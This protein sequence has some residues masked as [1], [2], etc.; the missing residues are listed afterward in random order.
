MLLGVFCAKGLAPL[1]CMAACALVDLL[2]QHLK[3]IEPEAGRKGGNTQAH[4]DRF[5]TIHKTPA[6]PSLAA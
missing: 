2:S 1:E 3:D 4:M 6:S 5:D